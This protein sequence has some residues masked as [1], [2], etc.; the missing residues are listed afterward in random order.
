MRPSSSTGGHGARL[1]PAPWRA[2]RHPFW[3]VSSLLRSACRRLLMALAPVM[4]LVSAVWL[5]PGAGAQTISE[6]VFLPQTYYV[7]DIVE[8][9]VVIRSTD[10]LDLV[11]PAA[12][13]DTPWV[14]LRSVQVLQRADGYEVRIVFQPFFIGTRRL[15]PI[16]MGA[17]TVSGVSA[18]VSRLETGA[19]EELEPE[20]VRDQLLLPG[21][22]LLIGVAIIAI[23]GAPLLV[24]LT[25]GWLRA[26]LRRLQARYRE[27]RPYRS[28]Q[29]GLRQLQT[30][31]HEL[32][33]KRFYIRLVD[34]LR[35]YLGGRF[36]QS[37]R[38]AT[39]G[40]LEVQLRREGIDTNHRRQLVEL[41]HFSDLVKFASHRVTVDDR[42]RHLEEVRS[43]SAELQKQPREEDQRVGA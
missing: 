12:L 38:S 35:D 4:L 9:R 17:L 26:T 23:I 5:P 40:E 10:V 28:L 11:V 13:P 31:M 39:T 16:P 32:D 3:L 18:V 8:A 2:H 42:S 20:P 1:W 29:K 14:D 19:G 22:E 41:F 33:G 7:G 15:P 27:N 34:L 24:L 25:G 30:D 37:L 6:V 43:I 36:S 21:T